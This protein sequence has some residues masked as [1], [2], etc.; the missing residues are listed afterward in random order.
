MNSLKIP[1]DCFELVLREI[2]TPNCLHFP[3]KLICQNSQYPEG[4]DSPLL[5]CPREDPIPV[6]KVS[7]SENNIIGGGWAQKRD[8]PSSSISQNPWLPSLQSPMLSVLQARWQDTESS[9]PSLS[10]STPPSLAQVQ[11]RGAFYPR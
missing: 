4:Q 8:T 5:V 6:L 10:H 11:S 3:T 2:L 9:V 7:S 1:C